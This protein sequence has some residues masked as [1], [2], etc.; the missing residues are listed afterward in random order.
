[1]TL[2][3]RVNRLTTDLAH[4]D[5][6]TIDGPIEAC[7][8]PPAHRVLIEVKQQDGYAVDLT[9]DLCADHERVAQLSSSYSR[10]WKLRASAASPT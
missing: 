4:F 8:E 9:V 7:G 3:C 6:I 10:S 2:V 1:M 5:G